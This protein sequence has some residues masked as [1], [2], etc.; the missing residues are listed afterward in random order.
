ME[1]NSPLSGPYWLFLLLSASSLVGIHAESDAAGLQR[2]LYE[3]NVGVRGAAAGE[4]PRLCCALLCCS[5]PAAVLIL[6]HQIH[7]VDGSPLGSLQGKAR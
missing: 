7:R 1:K 4:S 6:L 2:P 5:V 3:R